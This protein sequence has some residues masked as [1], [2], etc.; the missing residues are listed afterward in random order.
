[1][2]PPRR[3]EPCSE[4][5]P[6]EYSLFDDKAKIYRTKVAEERAVLTAQ[7]QAEIRAR[8]WMPMDGDIRLKDIPSCNEDGWTHAKIMD[9]IN[10]PDDVAA[11]MEE[12]SVLRYDPRFPCDNTW[13]PPPEPDTWE[14]IKS[15]GHG[16]EDPVDESTL[17]ERAGGSYVVLRRSVHSHYFSRANNLLGFFYFFSH[18]P[19]RPLPPP[20]QLVSYGF[21][22]C[23]LSPSL[24]HVVEK[25]VRTL[26]DDL[27]FIMNASSTRA[28]LCNVCA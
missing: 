22:F 6:G 28:V 21:L 15:I 9:L 26:L 18:S 25:H 12:H 16:T 11:A 20:P 27:D 3:R 19:A 14:F 7:R 10:F 5:T 4:E 2:S 23:L 13:I 8:S 1:M 17:G 24:C